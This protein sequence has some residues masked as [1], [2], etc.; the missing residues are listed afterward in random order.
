MKSGELHSPIHTGQV[1][2]K[3]LRFF[4]S[5][6]QGAHMPYHAHDDLLVCLELPRDVRRVLKSKLAS[7][8]GGEI[9]TLATADGIVTIAPHV[10]A[11]SLLEMVIE[12]GAPAARMVEREYQA[13]GAKA[14]SILTGDLGPEALVEYALAAAGRL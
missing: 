13:E 3:P 14:L 8:W 2:G 12:A 10:V 7:V 1:N 11:Q 4:R 9:R 6:S 5:P